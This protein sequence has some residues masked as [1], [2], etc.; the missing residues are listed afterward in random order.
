LIIRRRVRGSF[1]VAAMVRLSSVLNSAICL[2]PKTQ[3][4]W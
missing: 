1:P 4:G 2:P 3:D